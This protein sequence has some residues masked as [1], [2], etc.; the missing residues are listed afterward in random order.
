MKF[1]FTRHIQSCNNINIGERTIASIIGKNIDIEPAAT[2][3]GIIQT[4]E[5]AQKSENKECYN[6]DK[7]Y[8]SNLLRTWITAFL[9]YGTNLE[10]AKDTLKLYIS[11]YLKEYSAYDHILK[12]GSD[13]FK[14]GNYP[15]QVRE[16]IKN[17]VKFL[18]HLEPEKMEKYYSEHIPKNYKKWYYRLPTYVEIYLPNKNLIFENSNYFLINID[19]YDVKEFNIVDTIG[20][21]SS[22]PGFLKG[23]DLNKF[24]KWFESNDINYNYSNDLV[25][26]VSHSIVMKKFLYKKIK[27]YKKNFKKETKNKCNIKR[28]QENDEKCIHYCIKYSNCWKF[29]IDTNQIDEQGK[30][31]KIIFY[32]PGIPMD[33]K[34]SKLIEN[35]K[36]SLC[37][38]YKKSNKKSNKK[39]K[40][41]K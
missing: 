3:N 8:V 34:K 28:C 25:H 40:S 24:M 23:G 12:G 6:S 17:F 37:G 9:L 38:K 19:N 18:M 26:V 14:R 30:L 33:I 15:L 5:F 31:G 32:I 4:I 21:K 1:Q 13:P 35:P 39:S 29:K 41:N 10:N 36:H 27:D 7:V 11:P 16:T 20:P 22:Q 2:T